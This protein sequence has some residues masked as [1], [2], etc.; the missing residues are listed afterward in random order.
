MCRR[1][2]LH[3]RRN[4]V[5]SFVDVSDS[6]HE[7]AIC[8]ITVAGIT[9]GYSDRHYGP[10]DLVTRAQ[11]AS[12]L[13]RGLG[14]RAPAV[15]A[16]FPDVAPGGVHA[17]AIAAIAHAGITSGYSDGRYGPDDFVTRAQMASL[18]ARGLGLRA[19]AVPASFPDVTP[20]GVHASAIAAVTHAGIASGYR[21]GRYGVDDFV[22]RAQMAT[23]LARALNLLE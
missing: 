1:P 3:R 5:S 8:E 16:S 20:G 6:V 22:T 14:L 12:F 13:A 23:F 21:D 10:D 7:E 17:S 9:S 19:P 18:L 2:L 15:P 4:H 11:M